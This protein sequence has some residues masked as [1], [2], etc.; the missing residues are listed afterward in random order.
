MSRKNGYS[1]IFLDLGAATC[2]ASLDDA[3]S[4]AAYCLAGYLYTLAQ[5]GKTPPGPSQ[6]EQ[7]DPTNRSGRTLLCYTKVVT[8]REKGTEKKKAKR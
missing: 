3:F 2:G 5:D 8:V 4:M 6:P 1:V 7:I